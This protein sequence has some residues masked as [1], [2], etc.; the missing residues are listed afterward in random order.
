MPKE[1]EAPI[2]R[3]VVSGA[4]SF[5]SNN[6]ETEKAIQESEEIEESDVFPTQALP[7]ESNGIEPPPGFRDYSRTSCKD[8]SVYSLCYCLIDW[9]I[10]PLI[11]LLIHSLQPLINKLIHS[12]IQPF[13]H[14]FIHSFIYSF[15]HSA[16]H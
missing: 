4:H 5:V 12:L 1:S 13:I 7:S 8:F 15:I 10:V 16:I 3:L 14:S 6:K 2:V 9:S 11:H